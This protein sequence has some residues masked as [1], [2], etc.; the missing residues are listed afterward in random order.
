VSDPGSG[1][2]QALRAMAW[3][4]LASSGLLVL[5]APLW[6]AEG[7]SALRHGI[8]E[9]A[10]Q[11]VPHAAWARAGLALLGVAALLIAL[12]TAPARPLLTSWSLAAFGVAMM[13]SALWSHAPW[14][15]GATFDASEAQRHSLAAQAAG[16]A[17]VL[18]LGGRVAFRWTQQRCVDPLEVA[19][20]GMS[21]LVPL[22]WALR[23]PWPGAAQRAMFLLA[24]LWLAREATHT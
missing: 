4:S 22:A 11:G 16:M 23:F 15:A 8:S 24:Y 18:A 17:M 9:S 2:S 6:M 10:G 13:L 7:Y 3:L 12:R 14:M 19:A 21:V 20:L 1:A 5:A